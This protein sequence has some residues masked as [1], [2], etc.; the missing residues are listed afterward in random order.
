MG[1][2][3]LSS[4]AAGAV[5]ALAD[6]YLDGQVDEVAVY[7]GVLSGTEIMNHY[8]ARGFVPVPPTFTTTPLS[9]TVT[10]G[11]S[12]SFDATVLGTPRINLQWYKSG[13]PIKNAT[14]SSYAIPNTALGD[15]GV[16]TLWAT[17]GYGTNSVS[18]SLVV[19]SPTGYANVTNNLV[20][21][22]QFDGDTLDTSGHGNDGTPST[23]NSPEAPPVFVPGIIGTQALQYATVVVTNTGVST[24]IQSVSYVTLGTVGSGPP[25]DLQF[26]ASTS[27]S[28]SLWVKQPNGALFEDL[29]FIGTSTNSTGWP[30]WVLAPSVELGGWQFSLGNGT[31]TIDVNG[32]DNSI[33]DGNWHNFVLTVDRTAKVANGYLDGVLGASSSIASLGSLDNNNY[34][35]IVI[36][37][38]PTLHYTSPASHTFVAGTATLDDIG[39]WRQ[40]L[41]PLE[42]AQIASAGSTAGRSFNTVGPASVTLTITRSGANIVLGY[43]A[44]TLLQSSNLGT[45]AFWETVPGASAPS[46]TVTP[47][48]AAKFYRVQTP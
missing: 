28:V 1:P 19:I 6:L 16:Y 25:T 44:G 26:G 2:G 10:T 37:Q 8:T 42:V 3:R 21:H 32:P 22:L 40:A 33:N 13:N 48:N 4:A 29:P 47:T 41:T 18:A 24:N 36:G 23:S 12:I 17:N 39:I 27:F 5:A 31:T 35:P 43:T 30:G 9:Q 46:Y 7:K 11:K 20:L 38:D 14:N 34:W 45:G 15:S